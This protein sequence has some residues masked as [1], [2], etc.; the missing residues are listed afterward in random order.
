[1]FALSV[2][3]IIFHFGSARTRQF[4]SG[5]LLSEICLL[6]S[7]KGVVKLNQILS[8]RVWSSSGLQG[9]HLMS[10]EAAVPAVAVMI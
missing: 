2:A 3:S 7:F 6:P 9:L 1:M 5:W 4:G 8:P 10:P